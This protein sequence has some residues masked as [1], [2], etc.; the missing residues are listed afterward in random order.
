MPG[1]NFRVLLRKQSI[2]VDAGN[3]TDKAPRQAG[4]VAKCCLF[5]CRAAELLRS[6]LM[7]VED[8]AGQHTLKLLPALCQVGLPCCITWCA[9]PHLVCC[10]SPGVLCNVC[11]GIHHALCCVAVCAMQNVLFIMLCAVH[12]ALCCAIHCALCRSNCAVQ[13]VPCF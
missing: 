4:Y 8:Q 2:T 5:T 6:C 13:P 12:H 10:A 9:V 11:C 1:N 7:Y 3:C